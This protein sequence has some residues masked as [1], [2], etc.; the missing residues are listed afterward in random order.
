M[1]KVRELE[2]IKQ[3][4]L[5]EKLKRDEKKEFAILSYFWCKIVC[6][7]TKIPC[8]ASGL[9][10][11][12]LCKEIKK[13]CCGRKQC[14][15]NGKKRLW[16]M[17]YMMCWRK[18]KTINQPVVKLRNSYLKKIIPAPERM[19]NL[20]FIKFFYNFVLHLYFPS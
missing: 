17:W 6:N 7:C 1:A 19:S 13:S 15:I 3:I 4:E 8:E 2:T 16:R 18:T 5:D 10:Q 20:N 11:C 12:D 9:K 14:N